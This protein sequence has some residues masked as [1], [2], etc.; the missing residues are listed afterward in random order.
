VVAL[1]SFLILQP[2]VPIF[3]SLGAKN[4]WLAPKIWLFL[5]PVLSLAMTL[6]H[7]LLLIVSKSLEKTIT[8][9]FAW[10]TVFIQAILAL[11]LVRIIFIIS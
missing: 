5:F 11:S 10:A 9:L 8:Q 1:I 6:G 4:E 2:E 7:F 3:Y